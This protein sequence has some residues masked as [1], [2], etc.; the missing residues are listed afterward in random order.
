M[1]GGTYFNEMTKLLRSGKEVSDVG[2]ST[3]KTP[4]EVGDEHSEGNQVPHGQNRDEVPTD[5]SSQKLKAINVIESSDSQ[6]FEKVFQDAVP[7]MVDILK[8]ATIAINCS[9]GPI[10]NTLGGFN[11]AVASINSA[12][13]SFEKMLQDAVQV[14][15]K[16]NEQSPKQHATISKPDVALEESGN[17]AKIAPSVPVT[18]DRYIPPHRRDEVGLNNKSFAPN[19]LN[20]RNENSNNSNINKPNQ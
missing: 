10:N 1:L 15:S 13:G 18:D 14:F 11:S 16:K 3:N 12:V 20:G 8:Q 7:Q 9:I 2:D 5:Q 19:G 6:A 17:S 4:E